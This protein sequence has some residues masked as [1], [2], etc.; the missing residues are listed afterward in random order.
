MAPWV[1]R[2]LQGNLCPAKE[3]CTATMEVHLLPSSDGYLAFARV[4][5]VVCSGFGIGVWSTV[6]ILIGLLGGIVAAAEMRMR[7]VWVE[8]ESGDN[9]VLRICVSSSSDLNLTI[10][11]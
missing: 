10:V 11:T 1:M 6:V 3:L 4:R 9:L 5:G 8:V 2:S 7:S